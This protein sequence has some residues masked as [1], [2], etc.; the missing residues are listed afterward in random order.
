MPDSDVHVQPRVP[1][2]LG[3]LVAVE[4]HR[5]PGDRQRRGRAAG[6]RLLQVGAQVLQPLMARALGVQVLGIEARE[7]D[8]LTA[9]PGDG[10]IESPF[11]AGMAE[12]AEA[13]RDVAPLIGGEGER[14]QDRVPLLALRV[15]QVAHEQAVARLQRLGDAIRAELLAQPR[16]DEVA[17]TGVEGDDPHRRGASRRCLEPPDHLLDDL[18]RLGRVRVGPDRRVLDPA[19]RPDVR[20]VH[21]PQGDAV[22]VGA[23]V[24]PR[25]HGPRAREGQQATVIVVPVGERDEGLDPTA[26]VPG[27]GTARHTAGEAPVEDRLVLAAARAPRLPAAPGRPRGGGRRH[28]LGIPDDD[29]GA[30][31]PHGPHGARD[32]DLGGLVEDD[33]V[34]VAAVGWE[35]T[36]DRVRGDQEARGDG[37]HE[38]PVEVDQVPDV[39][40][41]L[42]ASDLTTERLGTRTRLAQRRLTAVEDDVE[43]LGGQGLAQ[44]LLGAP[45]VVEQLRVDGGVEGVQAG[46]AGAVLEG[47]PGP[48]PLGA[49]RTRDAVG[50]PGALDAPGVARLDERLAGAVVGG[51]GAALSRVVQPLPVGVQ[52]RP[53]R[54]QLPAQRVR[55]GA[56]GGRPQI[57]CASQ[58]PAD[59]DGLHVVVVEVEQEVP[60]ARLLAQAAGDDVERRELLRHEHDG[61]PRGQ[62]P[63]DEVRD[64]LR[65]ARP[66]RP[67]DD[68]AAPRRGIGDDPRLVGVGVQRQVLDDLVDVGARSTR[69]VLGRPAARRVREGGARGLQE[70]SDH[71]VGDDGR[72]VRLQV[73]PHAVG[74]EAEHAQVHGG[75]DDVTA[76]GLPQPAAQALQGG[77]D[78]DA[79]LVAHGLGELGEVHAGVRPEAGQQG[80]VG[81]RDPVLVQ[82]DAVRLALLPESDG[83][84]DEGGA[85]PV[86]VDA[87][88]QGADGQVE[89]VRPGLLQGR[90]GGDGHGPQALLVLLTSR[91]V[92]VDRPLLDQ[93]RGPVLGSRGVVRDGAQG[94]EVSGVDEVLE[95]ADELGL[96]EQL[97][98]VARGATDE[99]VAPGQVEQIPFPL[100]DGGRGGEA[101]DGGGLGH[102]GGRAVGRR[103]LGVHDRGGRSGGGPAVLRRDR[104]GRRRQ[105]DDDVVLIALQHGLRGRAVRSGGSD[106]GDEGQIGQ[107]PQRDAARRTG[108]LVEDR[109][110]QGRRQVGIDEAH[111][112]APD[113]VGRLLRGGRRSAGAAPPIP[114]IAEEGGLG[115]EQEGGGRVQPLQDAGDQG[116]DIEGAAG[117]RLEQPGGSA[118]EM[119]GGAPRAARGLD[120][121]AVP[122]QD[123][124]RSRGESVRVVGGGARAPAVGRDVERLGRQ[125]P[126]GR[127]VGLDE[128]RQRRARPALAPGEP[129]LPRG[130]HGESRDPAHGHRPVLAVQL[131][132]H[133]GGARL[134]HLEQVRAIQRQGAGARQRRTS[135][136]PGQAPGLDDLV[137]AVV[138]DDGERHVEDSRLGLPGAAGRGGQDPPL[139]AVGRGARVGKGAAVPREGQADRDHGG[140][141]RD[142]VGVADHGDALDLDADG[143][144]RIAAEASAVVDGADELAY[145]ALA[146]RGADEPERLAD[147]DEGGQRPV[148]VEALAMDRLV[149]EAA[150]LVQL[151]HQSRRQGQKVASVGAAGGEDADLGGQIGQVGEVRSRAVARKEGAQRLGRAAVPQ[152]GAEVALQVSRQDAEESSQDEVEIA[153]LHESGF[154]MRARYVE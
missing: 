22:A 34:D 114:P 10:D 4:V 26:V 41:P 19:L 142:G 117:A 64:R 131:D 40:G 21:A 107:R 44:P 136:V 6:A 35:E 72:P 75:F 39:Q 1:Q 147:R 80:V 30:P 38:V 77:L 89:V 140:G 62:G 82:D 119:G 87:P 97:D 7:H 67:L 109:G 65:L 92:D 81:G 54:G 110:R 137:P 49:L 146:P 124:A 78:V 24:R 152:G 139:L 113:E 63:E 104:A 98:D 2:A 125:G 37:D 48:L 133:M 144:E 27:Q 123:G 53:E 94:H 100:L 143:A 84:E 118:D 5:A 11:A 102:R 50:H 149:A 95:T 99:R 3:D 141:A 18:A 57:E 103:S 116:R 60:D 46:G 45:V 111:D 9:G 129:P 31:P 13:E 36:G 76:A 68:E 150:D 126:D 153:E 83:D 8:D 61:A 58:G 151:A 112:A 16:L 101:L 73:L 154:G 20:A 47:G 23:V 91:Q 28:L 115:G 120:G 33:D 51:G 90:T 79:V 29:H 86:A 66:G 148:G 25:G 88:C 56:G 108:Q 128:G 42:S 135:R 130:Q 93:Q 122:T 55:I 105:L 145:L 43:Q 59:I 138:L 15:L 71:R 106:R 96:H 134:L 32:R 12:R 14:E 121:D 70:V 74:G 85:H 69:C 132:S 52:A 17:L 127:L